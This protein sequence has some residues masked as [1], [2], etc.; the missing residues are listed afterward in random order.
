MPV[1][2]SHLH[3]ITYKKPPSAKKRQVDVLLDENSSSDSNNFSFTKQTKLS[4]KS[5]KTKTVNH[6]HKI[7]MRKVIRNQRKKNSKKQ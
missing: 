1:S 6:L 7:Q 5:D 4:I 3:R 2:E